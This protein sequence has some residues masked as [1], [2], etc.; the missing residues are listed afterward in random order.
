MDILTLKTVLVAEDESF[1]RKV[2]ATALT[3]LGGRVVEAADG[4]QALAM[5]DRPVRVDLV[6]LDVLMPEV[7]GLYVL[8]KIRAGQT[9]QDFSV[10]VML[11][12]ATRD[13]ASVHFAAGLSCDGFL[14]KPLDQKE[15]VTRLK[16]LFERRMALPYTPPHYRK[17]DVGPPDMPPSMASAQNAILSVAELEPGMVFTAP[18]FAKGRMIVPAGLPVTAELLT[19]LRGLEKVSPI[20]EMTVDKSF[21]AV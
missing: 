19:L 21:F 10:P 3:R 1:S 15:I 12:T 5:L 4:K 17:I 13:E 6:L 16:K 11:L 20:G 14:L 9:Y 8:Q 2:L 7:H 18:V